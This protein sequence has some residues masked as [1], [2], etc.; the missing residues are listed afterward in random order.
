[1]VQCLLI[2]AID[3]TD[4]H[5]EAIEVNGGGRQSEFGQLE[6]NADLTDEVDALCA[7]LLFLAR[8]HAMLNRWRVQQLLLT[9][10]PLRFGLGEE[11]IR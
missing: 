6:H 11:T 4:T 1:M 2:W 3:E 8:S 7:Y 5:E 10:E 9:E